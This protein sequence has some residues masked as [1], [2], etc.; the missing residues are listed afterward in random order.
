MNNGF[1]SISHHRA[2]TLKAVALP[3]TA[4][5][6]S[7]PLSLLI[8]ALLF[9]LLTITAAKGAEKPKAADLVE[10]GQAID[11]NL[12]QHI[13]LARAFLPS[14]KRQGRGDLIFMGS[15]AGLDG[16]P[17]GAVYSAAKAGLRGLARSLRRE[18]AGSGVRVCIINPG[19]VRTAFFDG[20]G[21][22]P[23]EDPSNHLRPRDL[24]ETVAMVLGAPPGTVFDEINLSPLKQIH[25]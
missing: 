20:L 10:D 3:I 6:G 2:I 5:F 7:R 14:L 1:M 22:G 18:C 23:G 24:A 19:M 25:T 12:T 8:S 21:F 17:K 11:L 4:A 9:L 13:F 15:E 16:G